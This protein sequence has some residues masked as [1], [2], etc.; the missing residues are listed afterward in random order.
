MSVWRTYLV[1]NEWNEIQTLRK[2]KIGLQ[3]VVF[4][5]FM[6]VGSIDTKK[7]ISQLPKKG[8]EGVQINGS[9]KNGRGLSPVLY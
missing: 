8:R 2:T 5:V 9:A 3:V 6:K 7:T 4:L 1:A